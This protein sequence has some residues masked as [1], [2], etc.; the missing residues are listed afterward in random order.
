MEEMAV[1]TFA[2]APVIGIACIFN[3]L[4]G[5]FGLLVNLSEQT[6]I[7]T[8][9]YYLFLTMKRDLQ[10]DGVETVHHMYAML[11]HPVCGHTP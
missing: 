6:C 9:S 5:R 4:T 8:K 2:I 3:R 10:I 1:G 11:L 7:T